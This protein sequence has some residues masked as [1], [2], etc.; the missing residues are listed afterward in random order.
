MKNREIVFELDAMCEC[1]YLIFITKLLFLTIVPDFQEEI[2]NRLKSG[3]ACYHSVQDLVS[4]SLLSKNVKFKIYR[5]I[6]N[7]ACCFVL[8]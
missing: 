8:M 5:I 3:N 7:L 2:K 6:Y 1:L 4:H